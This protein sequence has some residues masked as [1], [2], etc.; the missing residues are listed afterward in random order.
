MTERWQQIE[1]IFEE[2]LLL[3][4]PLRH[5]RLLELTANDPG[6]RREVESLLAQ[7]PAESGFLE[8]P[9]PWRR[10]FAGRSWEISSWENSSA[11]IAWIR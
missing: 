2:V 4:E 10:I 8:S 9:W 3:A 5:A 11:V 1:R 6:L 7:Q